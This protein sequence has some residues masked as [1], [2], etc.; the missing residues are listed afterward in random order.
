VIVCFQDLSCH[1]V[2]HY[3]PHALFQSQC[4]G[5]ALPS[6]SGVNPVNMKL[7]TQYSDYRK[8]LRVFL[9]LRLLSDVERSAAV[10]QAM[11]RRGCRRHGRA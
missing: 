8:K 5:E 4:D 7:V 6:R 10:L 3:S 11:T 1:F 9:Q 2:S